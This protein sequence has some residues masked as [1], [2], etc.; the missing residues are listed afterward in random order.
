MTTPPVPFGRA[1]AARH[2]VAGSLATLVAGALILMLVAQRN[3]ARLVILLPL[4]GTP[5]MFVA[6]VAT[7]VLLG[8][9]SMLVVRRRRRAAVIVANITG[10]AFLVTAC[11][12]PVLDMAFE[13]HRDRRVAVVAV[14][15]DGSLEIALAVR[16]GASGDYL[17]LRVR[18][19][20]G[21]L[22]RYARYP[23]AYLCNNYP[24]EVTFTSPVEVRVRTN[25]DLEGT[26]R[27]D[28]VTLES[29]YLDDC[30]DDQG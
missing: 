5:A 9:A 22:S 20:D 6:L 26:V 2:A 21:L 24:T 18:S 14:S 27:L 30:V 25:G 16:Y 1:A 10:C 29:P 11:A 4:Q 15:P 8:L 3:P 17:I 28:P 23:M 19:R 13:H 7:P 12:I